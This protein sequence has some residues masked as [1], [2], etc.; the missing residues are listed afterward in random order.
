MSMA[1]MRQEH[2]VW[3][4]ILTVGVRMLSQEYYI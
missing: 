3:I 1:Y 2:I 4:E